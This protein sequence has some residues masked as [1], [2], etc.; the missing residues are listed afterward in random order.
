MFLLPVTAFSQG[1]VQSYNSSNTFNKV[2]TLDANHAFVVGYNGVLLRTTTGGYSWEQIQTNT[3]EN[4]LDVSFINDSI[5]FICG[6]NG[7]LLK[8]TNGGTTW[9][10]CTT[11]T[12]L[13]LCGIC[14]VNNNIGWISGS[15]NNSGF[16]NPSD[17]G[18]IIKTINGGNSF[19]L[20]ESIYEGIR[21]VGAYNVDTCFAICDSHILKTTNSGATWQTVI[22]HPGVKFTSIAT[23]PSGLSYIY[24]YDCYHYQTNNYGISWDSTFAEGLEFIDISFP[25][26]LIGYAA[27]YDPLS[28]YGAIYNTN[29]GDSTWN[30]SY[31]GP[32]GPMFISVNFTNDS[33]GFAVTSDGYIYK[34]G[35]ITGINPESQSISSS[36]N[37]YPNPATDKITIKTSPTP[38]RSQLTIMNLNGE[39]ILTQSL[40]KPKTQIDISSL[41][42][43]VYFVRLTNDRTVEVR[44][45]VK[46]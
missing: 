1:W 7:T 31:G 4:L 33:I 15:L 43:G 22:S 38:T 37:V 8:S 20:C 10:P 35:L 42:S 27:M 16:P 23:F 41:P 39:E 24:S 21:N 32:S 18:I 2:F 45:F 9:N 12:T 29:N 3:T 11:N 46:E 25:T 44:K 28:Y 34:H 19:T 17:T 26:P 40:I 5:G 30:L 36:I 14:F 6:A 13:A